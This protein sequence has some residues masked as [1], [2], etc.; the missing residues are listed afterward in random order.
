[1]AFPCV[2]LHFTHCVDLYAEETQGSHTFG[3]L[4][5]Q[6]LEKVAI[7]AAWPLEPPLSSAQSDKHISEF[8]T[9]HL[10]Y[11]LLCFTK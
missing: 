9:K 2:P 1:M 7:S 3:V 5:S 8:M 4:I 10:A 6:P 11:F